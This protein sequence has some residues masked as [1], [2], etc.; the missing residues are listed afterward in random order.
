MNDIERIQ[1]IRQARLKIF[2]IQTEAGFKQMILDE[3][4]GLC[5]VDSIT[6]KENYK[7]S[8]KK[9]SSSF[10]Y[11]ARLKGRLSLVF[12]RNSPFS[13]QE[14]KVFSAAAGAAA[15][16]LK[17]IETHQ[18]LKTLKKQWKSAFNAIEKPIC[19]TDDSFNILSTNDCFIRKTKKSKVDLYKKNCFSVF[20]DSSLS[21]QEIKT[22]QQ[23]KILK[24]PRGDKDIYEVHCQSFVKNQGSVRLVIFTDITEKMKMQK[25]ITRLNESAQMGIIA[26]SIAHEL[27]NPLS[28]ARLLLEL[29]HQDPAVLDQEKSKIK[30]M[31]HAV[32]RCEQMVSRLLK[33]DSVQDL[34][35]V[36]LK[37]EDKSPDPAP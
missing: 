13:P 28:G 15:V 20:F 36:S 4:P 31:L 10:A 25:K 7:N 8:R 18:Q 6:I 35:Q 5:G 22:L 11:G 32:E 9:T 16:S 19:L 2:Q 33:M 3:L 27:T 1:R 14:K 12:A 21:L 30:P 17:R 29:I 26:S 23:S 37:S 24:S 34:L